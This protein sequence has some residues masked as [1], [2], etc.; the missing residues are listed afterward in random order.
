M[1][2]DRN[3]YNN[4]FILYLIKLYLYY[5]YIILKSTYQDYADDYISKLRNC[6]IL[7]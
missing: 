4:F 7:L 1:F 6:K 5:N 2:K 3:N